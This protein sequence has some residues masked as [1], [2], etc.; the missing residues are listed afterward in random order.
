MHIVTTQRLGAIKSHRQAAFR[1]AGEF[2]ATHVIARLQ[3]QAVRAIVFMFDAKF[4]EHLVHVF[5]QLLGALGDGDLGQH[6]VGALSVKRIQFEQTI[7]PARQHQFDGAG[8]RAGGVKQALYRC[9]VSGSGHAGLER[10]AEFG[11][12]CRPGRTDVLKRIDALVQPAHQHTLRGI[13]KARH[14]NLDRKALADAIEAANAL[15]NEIG[16]LRHIEQHQMSRKLEIA[17]FA[18]DFRTHQQLRVFFGVGEVGGGAVTGD[19]IEPFM[20]NRRAYPFAQPQPGFQR[21]C[22]VGTRADHQGLVATALCQPV[23][24]PFGARVEAQPVFAETLLGYELRR[25]CR[26]VNAFAINARHVELMDIQMTLGKA[27]DVV[28]AIAEQHAPGAVMVEQLTHDALG[29]IGAVPGECRCQFGHT[30]TTEVARHFRHDGGAW[31]SGARMQ[32]AYQLAD[33]FVMFFLGEIACEIIVTMGVEQTQ[34]REMTFHTE[35]FGGCGQQQQRGYAFGEGRNRD[36]GR[37]RGGGCPGQV[38]GF[39]DHHQIPACS[40]GLRMT[41]RRGDQEG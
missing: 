5:A 8:T 30:L 39:V 25:E 27:G 2:R 36:I 19:Q 15:F 11:E 12:Q 4:A 38:M 13:A 23:R 20:K 31:C 41:F 18:A 9:A 40:A 24:Q 7:T 3:H 33:R 22:G 14:M 28:A 32:A 16:I 35:L 17:A 10:R 26:A 1:Q 34:A 21:L 6:D 29:A 37:A